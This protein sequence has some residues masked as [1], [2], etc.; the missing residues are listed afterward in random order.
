[1][2]KNKHITIVDIK[3][4]HRWDEFVMRHPYGTVFHSSAWGEVLE[5]T[6]GYTPF[7]LALEGG[8]NSGFDGVVPFFLVQHRLT[9]NM[10]VSLPLT[11]YCKMLIPERDF[12]NVIDFARNQIS[13]KASV[14][15]KFYDV[16]RFKSEMFEKNVD[17]VTHILSIDLDLDMTYRKFHD[18]SIRQKIKRAENN[19]LTL[20]IG[21]SEQDLKSFYKLYLGIRKKHGL[22]PHTYKF[23]LNM[24]KILRPK[25]LM[26]VPLVM[27]GKDVVAAAIVLK[28]KNTHHLEYS[29]SDQ[30]R[31]N[32]FPNHKLIWNCIQIAHRAGSSYF[33]FGRS[34]VTNK[35][36][37]SF[38]ERWG[39]VK[40]ELP[41]CYYPKGTKS[42][43]E[44]GS[45][46]GIL[47]SI[48]K[49]LP[50]FL[51]RIEGYIVYQF[52]M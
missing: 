42:T 21:E 24:W 47:K 14:L 32:L 33:D 22:P 44:H 7:Y 13:R 27:Y 52:I 30:D 46:F 17:Y 51:L 29:A 6:Y 15:I 5:S 26:T 20:R 10:L 35:S 23:F 18:T 9:G 1:M 40:H 38:K 2:Y 28:S 45:A 16:N 31:L 25:N 3:K 19:G 50:H 34:S 39:A 4:D 41:Y 8:S 12:E 49:K 11:S 36:L 48:N 37:I 43:M